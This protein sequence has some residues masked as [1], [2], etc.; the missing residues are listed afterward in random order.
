MVVIGVI[1]SVKLSLS[2]MKGYHSCSQQ[3]FERFTHV[4]I[5]IVVAKVSFT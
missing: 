3:W 4:N 1:M 5:E 2:G